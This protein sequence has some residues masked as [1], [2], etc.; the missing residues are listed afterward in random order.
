L[1]WRKKRSICYITLNND[2]A[3][4]LSKEA[5]ARETIV[6]Q[7]PSCTSQGLFV[8]I[9][10]FFWLVSTSQKSKGETN[11]PTVELAFEKL[12]GGFEKLN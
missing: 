8:S 1:G 12:K 6:K 10:F 9:F 7:G 4:R 3:V 11:N 5:E 2:V